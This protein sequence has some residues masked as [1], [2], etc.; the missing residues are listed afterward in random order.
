MID[1]DYENVYNSCTI[2]IVI[3]VT[4]SLIIIGISSEF[5]YFHWHLKESNTNITSINANTETIIC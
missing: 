3:F 1:N 4:A 2:Y 5:F